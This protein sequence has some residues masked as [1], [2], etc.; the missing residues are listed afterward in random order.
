MLY[1]QFVATATSIKVCVSIVNA[2]H[3]C[4]C[5]TVSKHLASCKIGTNILF[6]R[7]TEL[8]SATGVLEEIRSQYKNKEK[9]ITVDMCRYSANTLT[10]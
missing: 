2:S 1:L 9:S 8:V 10:A 6:S 5:Q 7:V 4:L 3:V